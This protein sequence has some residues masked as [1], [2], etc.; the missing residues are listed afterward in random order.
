MKVEKKDLIKALEEVKPG[1]ANK[2]IIA[3]STSFIFQDGYITTFNDEIA[4]SRPFNLD[5]TGAV[6]ANELYSLLS[7]TKDEAI[8]FE[9][10]ENELKII[11]KKS[12]AGIKL[13]PD[14]LLPADE[15]WNLEGGYSDLPA[16]FLKSIRIASYCAS[17]DMSRPQLTCVCIHDQYA[18]ASDGFRIIRVDLGKRAKRTFKDPLLLSASAIK[19]LVKYPV[20][21]FTTTPGWIHFSTETG[22]TFSCRAYGDSYPDVSEYL[23]VEGEEFQFPDSTL[24]MLER[25]GIFTKENDGVEF[26][27]VTVENRKMTLKGEGNFGWIEETANCRYKG[28]K[29]EFLIDPLFLKDILKD[30]A[31]C[32]VGDTALLFQGDNFEH[33]VSLVVD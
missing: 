31:K 4:I 28:S 7:K 1:L 24:E 33:V 15:I 23:A 13:E 16:T 32:V 26:V 9:A 3:Q 19:F 20:I 22:L 5:I 12:K 14:V 2:D 25:T 27:K 29:I 10:T 17:T 6:R 8:E 11:G 21:K 18:V 30:L